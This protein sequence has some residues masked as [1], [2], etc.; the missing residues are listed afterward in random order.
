MRMPLRKLS[1]L[2]S[3]KLSRPAQRPSSKSYPAG[4]PEGCCINHKGYGTAGHSDKGELRVTDQLRP[5][6]KSP[7]PFL[8]GLCPF[9]ECELSAKL[10]M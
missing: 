9:I 10:V 2:W 4:L 1:S 6:R 8:N 7:E 5:S 3:L